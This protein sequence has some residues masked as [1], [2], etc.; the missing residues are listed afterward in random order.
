MCKLFMLGAVAVP[1]FVT[2]SFEIWIIFERL[3]LYCV[4]LTD[5][6]VVR[7]RP[8]TAFELCVWQTQAVTNFTYLLFF[9]PVNLNRDWVPSSW[10]WRFG[11]WHRATTDQSCKSNGRQQFIRFH[12]FEAKSS[13]TRTVT[14]VIATTAIWIVK[15]VKMVSMIF[16]CGLDDRFI[17]TY[18]RLCVN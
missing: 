11:N 9:Q 8:G 16:L 2:E 1:N 15:M 14:I 6:N 10:R 3:W 7:F 18:R 12:D 4:N 17:I 13:E 5:R